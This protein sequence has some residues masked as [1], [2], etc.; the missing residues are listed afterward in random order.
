VAFEG[1]SFEGMTLLEAMGTRRD[2]RR[3]RREERKTWLFI[4]A[5]WEAEIGSGGE[6]ALVNGGDDKMEVIRPVT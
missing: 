5:A 1:R 6:K 3:S 4:A 2:R